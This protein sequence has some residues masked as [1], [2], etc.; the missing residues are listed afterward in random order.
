MADRSALEAATVEAAIDNRILAEVGLAVGVRASLGH[1]HMRV[2]GDPN[3]FVVK[4]RGYRMDVLSRM[5]PEDMVVCDLED[6]WVDGPPY[7]L[8]C[9]EV[10]I[11]SCLDKNRPDVVSV[12]HVPPDDAV[13]MRV[14]QNGLT[15]MAQEGARLVINPL[16]VYPHTKILTSE[17]EGQEVARLLGYGEAYLLLGHRA[18]TAS[19]VGGEDAVL[20]MG[21]LEHQTRLN[22]L[23]M[24]AAAPII[25][26][27][28]CPWPRRSP[29]LGPRR[30]P[31]SKPAW[32]PGTGGRPH[33]GIWADFRE[34]VTANM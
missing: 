28:R 21:H 22:S 25:R 15:P 1:G 5:H 3:L 18:V 27:S 24:C 17:E 32:P 30:S 13:L 29:W 2:P 19:P 16:P 33:G 23:P 34:V 14:L 9:S 20:A 31:T 7:S 12:V 26:P 6:H 11:H 10:K 8:Q 4:G